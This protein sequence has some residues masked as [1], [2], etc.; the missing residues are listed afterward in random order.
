VNM[1]SIKNFNYMA[2]AALPFIVCLIVADALWLHPGLAAFDEVDALA[3]A[4]Q[5]LAGG[6]I[7]WNLATGS[8]ARAAQVLAGLLGFGPQAALRA[9]MWLA[10]VAENALLWKLARRYSQ[11]AAAASLLVNLFAAVTL[12]RAHS[13]LSWSWVPA[14][15]LAALLALTSPRP[16]AR[17]AGGILAG[18]L[19]LDYE[20]WIGGVVLLAVLALWQN[21]KDARGQWQGLAGLLGGLAFAVGIS[22]RGIMEVL[23]FRQ[24][25]NPAA[26]SHAGLNLIRYWTGHSGAPYL[27]LGPQPQFPL[28][29]LPALAVGI[30]TAAQRHRDLLLWAAVGFLPLAASMAALEA[31]R[32][33]LAW[34]ALCLL[35]GLGLARI[36]AAAGNKKAAA[37]VLA[38]WVVAGGAWEYGR[39]FKLMQQNYHPLWTA[40]ETILRAASQAQREGNTVLLDLD[41]RFSAAGLWLEKNKGATTGERLVYVPQAML[42]LL[43][44]QAG[45]WFEYAGPAGFKIKLLKPNAQTGGWLFPLLQKLRGLWMDLPRYRP[46]L[47]K[48]AL[49]KAQSNPD[50]SGPLAAEALATTRRRFYWTQ[51]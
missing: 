18:L 9:P 13:V 38:C 7:D 26:L 16:L 6:G 35:G 5:A 49:D 39:Y 14:L 45:Q 33:I 43:G 17:A 34:P 50:F 22:Q 40:P 1:N 31:N 41:S 2:C 21:H 20:V 4:A 37:F 30:F 19:W 29:A 24:A 15:M 46:A 36:A 3:A 51:P 8:L 28:W 23:N 32:A 11:Q 44:D 47:L 27:T 25:Q 48:T 42:P 12:H 10:F